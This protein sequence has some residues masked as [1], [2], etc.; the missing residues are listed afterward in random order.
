MSI[1]VGGLLLS[2]VGSFDRVDSSVAAESPSAPAGRLTGVSDKETSGLAAGHCSKEFWLSQ[3]RRL[4]D[5]RLKV[6][7]EASYRRALSRQSSPTLSSSS[8]PSSGSL[9]GQSSGCLGWDTQFGL[10]GG[11]NSEVFAMAV[12]GR[13]LYVGGSFIAIGG[14]S[15]NRIARYDLDTGAWSTLG[16]GGGNGVNETVTSL[17]VVGTNL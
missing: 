3:A 14:V 7:K 4:Q 2:P 15:A 5:G 10:V 13:S 9:S 16:S 12:V 1:L 17:A 8:G 11:P 6:G